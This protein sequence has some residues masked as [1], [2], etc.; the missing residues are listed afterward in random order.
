M[1]EHAL[2]LCDKSFEDVRSGFKKCEYCLGDK[3][4]K[5][6]DILIFC[7]ESRDKKFIKTKITHIFSNDNLPKDWIIISFQKCKSFTKMKVKSFYIDEDNNVYLCVNKINRKFMICSLGKT[8][9]GTYHAEW[10]NEQGKGCYFQ[11][12]DECNFDLVFEKLKDHL[13]DL[14]RGKTG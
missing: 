13:W 11:L 14:M 1:T 12:V 4:Y 2:V 6:G 8:H 7:S 10:V 5:E 3:N 9:K